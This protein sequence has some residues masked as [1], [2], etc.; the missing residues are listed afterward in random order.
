MKL[1]HDQRREL[2]EWRQNNPDAH[3]P[4]HAKKPPHAKKACVTG[5]PGKSNQSQCL[6]HNK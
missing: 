4:T 1:T 3:K 2:S 5:G 6:S